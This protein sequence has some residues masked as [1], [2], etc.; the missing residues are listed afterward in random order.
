[1]KLGNDGNAAKR[2]K[3]EQLENAISA[4]TLRI[5]EAKRQHKN[6]L[7]TNNSGDNQV[8]QNLENVSDD[9]E[10]LTKYP[11]MSGAEWFGLS[12]ADCLYR[13]YL[14][15]RE[16]KSTMKRFFLIKKKFKQNLQAKQIY[17]I[18][19]CIF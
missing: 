9:F 3:L 2:R 5:L 13:G 19:K 1:M 12:S 18:F 7:I 6:L 8:Q 16:L 11:P 15:G 10:K 4:T 17:L 14:S